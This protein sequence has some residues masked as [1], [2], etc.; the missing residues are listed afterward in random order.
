LIYSSLF[1]CCFKL[2]VKSFTDISSGFFPAAKERFA[3][4]QG[5]DFKILD[6]GKDPIEQGF[7][8]GSFDLIVASN[9]LHATPEL[10]TT[11][12]NVRKLLSPRGQLFLLELQPSPVKFINLIMG[13]LP[14]WWLGEADGRPDQ[15]FV[16]VER[17]DVELKKAGFRGVEAAVYNEPRKEYQFCATIISRLPQP[18]KD[19]SVTLLCKSELSSAHDREVEETLTSQGFHVDRRTFKQ[20][21]PPHQDIISIIELEDPMFHDISED[22][23]ATYKSFL[24]N[25][26]SAGVLWVTKSIQMNCEDPRHAL[27]L[28]L[29]RA[30]RTE[31]SISLATLELDSLNRSSYEAIIKVFDKFHARTSTGAIDPDWEYTFHDGKINIGRFHWVS[32]SKEL[33]SIVTEDGPMKLDIGRPGLLRSLGWVNYPLNKLGPDDVE[34]AVQCVGLNFRVSSKFLLS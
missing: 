5:I 27:T 34:I 29:S 3:A 1:S 2:T 8:A 14:G 9:V 20:E 4:Y 32:V 23:F 10:N 15:P 19:R 18:E 26:G 22:D 6:I 7:E 30:M 11:L 28:G 33:S 21:L 16:M 13:V 17:W 12:K 24:E 31:L 25:L